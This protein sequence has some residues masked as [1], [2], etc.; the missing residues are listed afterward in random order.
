MPACLLALRRLGR[1]GAIAWML[2]CPALARAQ[3][4]ATPGIAGRYITDLIG[5]VSGGRQRGAAWLGRLDVM[6]DSHEGVFGIPGAQLHLDLFLLHGR[7]FS[8]RNAG[9][10]QVASNID[11][12]SAFRPFEAWIA[13]PIT[14]V[15]RAKAGLID[16]NSEFDQQS[17]G[18][19]FL[20]SS[21]GIG[22]DFSQ[23]GRNGPSIFPVTSPGLVLIAS[24]GRRTAR[25]A[26]FDAVAGDEAHPGR[27]L[28]G[29]LGRGG[30][31]FAGEVEVP[32]A[33]GKAHVG[34]WRYTDRF[35]S[36]DGTGRGHSDGGYAQIEQRL[37]GRE[38]GAALRGWLRI[39][40][41]SDRVNA[42][43][44]YA[45]GGISYGDKDRTVGFAIAHA[46][47]GDP[48]RRIDEARR[49]ET[50]FELVALHRLTSHLVVQ[51]DLQYIRH[52]GW[53]RDRRD[54][55]VLA[56]RFRIALFGA[57]GD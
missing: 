11:A 25:I 13:A 47:L 4:A 2:S 55:L 8:I 29:A 24:D 20:N 19:L 39:G 51:P 31:L 50:S 6:A 45:G 7:S 16:L 32:I 15:V 52:P 41:A 3:D 35:D 5:D 18:D 43:G 9:D 36:I 21:F 54:A 48:A 34:V 27:F 38:D 26:V 49:A 30:A 42:I 22:P 10:A 46:R 44:T 56:L 14:P 1:A 40:L 12:P 33:T 53:V 17:L 37:L 23:S 57:A 28:P